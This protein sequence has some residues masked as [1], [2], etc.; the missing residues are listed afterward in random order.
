[1]SEL[2]QDAPKGI[3]TINVSLLLENESEELRPQILDEQDVKYFLGVRHNRKTASLTISNKQ[4]L[5][6]Q[7]SNK[8]FS[9]SEIYYNSSSPL[10]KHKTKSDQIILNVQEELDKLRNKCRCEKKASCCCQVF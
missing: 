5:K 10:S 2:D 3:Y 9:L 1:M 6:S 4:I 7:S 8:S